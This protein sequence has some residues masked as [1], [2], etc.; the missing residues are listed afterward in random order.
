M[1]VG[2]FQHT[3]DGKGRLILPSKFRDA[4]ADGLVITKGMEGC[5][6]IFPKSEW[7]Q[8]EDKVRSLPLTKKDARKFSRFFFAGATEEVLSKQGRVLIPEN[9]RKYAGLEKDIVV[10]GVSNR[11]E[12]WDKERWAAYSKEAGESYENVAE[13]LTDL[14]I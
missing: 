1:F 6:F 10:I 9:L 7:P 3:L 11:L 13:E 14:G 4:L 5:L 8:L 2:E 12:I